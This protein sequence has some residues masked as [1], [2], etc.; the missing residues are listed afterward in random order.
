MISLKKYLE[1][2]SVDPATADSAIPARLEEW[3]ILPATMRAYRSALRE[4]GSCSVDACPGLG[5]GLKRS[6][7][8]LGE[9]LATGMSPEALAAAETTV[10]VHLQD[11]GRNAARHYRQKAGEVRELLI[12]MARTT[13]AV[14]ERDQR[15]AGQIHEV[16]RRLEGIASLED[17]S[18]IRASIKKNAAELKESVDRMAAEGRAAVEG[19]RAQVSSYQARLEEA[20]EISSRDALTGLRSRLCVESQ[21]ERRIGC[22]LPLCVA[23]LDIDGFKKVNDRHGHLIGDELLKQFATELTSVCRSTDLIGRWG[24]DEFIIL[25]ECGLPEA[26]TQADRLREWVCGSYK[27][28]ADSGHVSLTVDVSIG[29]AECLPGDTMRDVLN[30]AD[31]AMYQRKAASRE[32]GAGAS[33]QVRPERRF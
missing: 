31:A 25:L 20:E 28:Q 26:S 24:G 11:W 4:M 14:G 30:R 6:L 12:V 13:E 19:L 33:Q 1:S 21:I 5:E 2:A 22:G 29:V 27:I 8:K 15:C 32:S 3:E 23:I 18:E 16:T 10:S 9:D 17:L 7:N